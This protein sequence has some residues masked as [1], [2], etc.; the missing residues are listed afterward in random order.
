MNL[1]VQSPELDTDGLGASCLLSICRGLMRLAANRVDHDLLQV[2]LLQALKKSFEVPFFV[3]VA[4]ALVHHVPFAQLFRK[5]S[6]RRD[7]AG[8][9]E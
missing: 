2:G 7:R 5:V 9:P 1:G 6:P 3:P 8:Y 4:I